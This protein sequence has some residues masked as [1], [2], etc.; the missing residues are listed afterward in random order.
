LVDNT[1][2]KFSR[3]NITI[4]TG[5]PLPKHISQFKIYDMDAD[6]RDDIAYITA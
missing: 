5:N 6:S 1:D 3:P 2:R 4:D